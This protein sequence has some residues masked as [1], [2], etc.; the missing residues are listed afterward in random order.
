VIRRPSRPLVGALA[1]YVAFMALHVVV[2][3]DGG[4]VVTSRWP[5]VGPWLGPVGWA[6]YA[7]FALVVVAVT[8]RWREVGLLDRPAPGWLRLAAVPCAAGLPFLL[9]SWNLDEASVVPLLVVGVP[10]VALNEEL[11][12]RGVLLDHL[13]PLG[14]RRA[15]TWTAVL[16]GASHVVNLVSGAFPP[17]VAMQVAATTAGGV[18]LAAI[19]L[20]TGSLWPVLLVHLVIDLIAVATLTGP[21]TSSPI[22][23]PVL[24]A[25]LIANLALWGWGWRVLRPLL[26]ASRS[27]PAAAASVRS[28]GGARPA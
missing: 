5:E 26:S 16:F 12:F 17:F 9:L 15:V 23:L 7:S 1:I 3:W 4:V 24:F 10:L 20:R 14:I 22:L 11:L 8:R 18:G 21:A 13:A 2:A 28:H 19:R 6:L 27:V 25:W